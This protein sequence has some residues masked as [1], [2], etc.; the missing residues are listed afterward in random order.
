[1]E[2]KRE[3]QG[4]TRDSAKATPREKPAKTKPKARAIHAQPQIDWETDSKRNLSWGEKALKTTV[5]F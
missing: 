2:G 3:F 5:Q 4:L 1:M